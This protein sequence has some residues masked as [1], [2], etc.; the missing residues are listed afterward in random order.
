LRSGVDINTI[1]AWMGHVSLAKTNI[2]AEVDVE[3]NAK[4]LAHCEIREDEPNKPRREDKGLM[5]FFK[6]SVTTQ[7]QRPGARDATIATTTSTRGSLQR[8]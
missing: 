8:I 3:V 7:A 6:N 4:A 5:E 2:Y 1:R